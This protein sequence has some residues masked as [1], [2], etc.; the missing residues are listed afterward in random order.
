MKATGKGG[1]ANRVQLGA[2]DAN[3]SHSISL[4]WTRVGIN[5]QIITRQDLHTVSMISDTLS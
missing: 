2:V 5:S 4:D 3:V 1:I